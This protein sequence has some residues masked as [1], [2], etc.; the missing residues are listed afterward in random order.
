[1]A[2]PAQRGIG[3]HFLS[4]FFWLLIAKCGCKRRSIFF[5]QLQ[6]LSSG[7]YCGMGQLSVN[8]A[9][10]VFACVHPLIHCTIWQIFVFCRPCMLMQ[11]TIST[12]K[13]KLLEFRAI[14]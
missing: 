4:T 1:M 5:P 7:Y 14:N 3:L 10:L 6:L 12:V 2:K 8:G 11:F 9:T 13:M